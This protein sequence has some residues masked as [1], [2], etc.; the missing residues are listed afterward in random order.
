M[1]CKKILTCHKSFDFNDLSDYQRPDQF[2]DLDQDSEQDISRHPDL[3]QVQ[4]PNQ[5]KDLCWELNPD[6]DI[7]SAV[8]RIWL[9]DFS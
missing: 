4:N 7:G 9:I 8:F 1:A 3:D 6:L 2:L 5:D